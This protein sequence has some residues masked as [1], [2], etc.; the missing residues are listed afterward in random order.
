LSF[1][2]FYKINL[3]LS[4]L[5]ASVSFVNASNGNL[6]IKGNEEPTKKE[7]VERIDPATCWMLADAIE[8]Q[9]CGH[10]GCDFELWEDRYETCLSLVE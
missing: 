4:L 2:N 3:T 7:K 1:H 6:T 5:I 9:H 10:V 8:V